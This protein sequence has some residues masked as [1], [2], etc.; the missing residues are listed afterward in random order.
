M[1]NETK[2]GILAQC[3][4]IVVSSKGLVDLIMQSNPYSIVCCGIAGLS[5]WWQGLRIQNKRKAHWLG[6]TASFA[7]LTASSCLQLKYG[8][9]AGAVIDGMLGMLTGFGGMAA[10]FDRK[11]NDEQK[12][13]ASRPGEL[14]EKLNSGTEH[15]NN[16]E[17]RQAFSIYNS[18]LEDALANNE[19]EMIDAANAHLFA[20]HV[21]EAV[22]FAQNNEEPYTVSA[23][24]DSN[25]YLARLNEEK[26]KRM[27]ILNQRTLARLIREYS[28][29]VRSLGLGA[30]SIGAAPNSKLQTPN[31]KY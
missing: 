31:Q 30:W 29:W 19:Q 10:Y 16:Y 17:F 21:Q 14:E 12:Q 9:Y 20:A 1:D 26:V 27:K 25:K 11:S 23:M 7:T 28:S 13:K 6:Y 5:L 18:V 24:S 15:M 3:S 2:E 22:L 4:G 8:S